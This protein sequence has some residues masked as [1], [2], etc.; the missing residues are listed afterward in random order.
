MFSQLCEGV[1]EASSTNTE[2]LL[3]P[4]KPG[5][6][7]APYLYRLAFPKQDYVSLLRALEDKNL[8][9]LEA[10]LLDLLPDAT[11]LPG[12]ES[13]EWQHTLQGIF[14]IIYERLQE[15]PKLYDEQ[16]IK[17]G[18]LALAVLPDGPLPKTTED[19]SSLNEQC[20]TAIVC[21]LFSPQES[22]RIEF[23][24]AVYSR[25]LQGVMAEACWNSTLTVVEVS[26]DENTTEKIPAVA[27]KTKRVNNF[28]DT[29]RGTIEQLDYYIQLVGETLKEQAGART[30]NRPKQCQKQV[31]EGYREGCPD[32]NLLQEAQEQS[33]ADPEYRSFLVDPYKIERFALEQVFIKAQMDVIFPDQDLLNSP[34][35]ISLANSRTED[36]PQAIP[37]TGVISGRFSTLQRDAQASLEELSAPVIEKFRLPKSDDAEASLSHDQLINLRFL[38]ISRH[39]GQFRNFAKFI[40][41]K[42]PILPFIASNNIWTIAER[43][44]DAPQ[45][46][47]SLLHYLVNEALMTRARTGEEA[48]DEE[49]WQLA[50]EHRTSLLRLATL[51]IADF[52]VLINANGRN[53]PLDPYNSP[54]GTSHHGRDHGLSREEDG[55]LTLTLPVTHSDAIGLAKTREGVTLGCPALKEKKQDVVSQPRSSSR[56]ANYIDYLLAVIINEARA[57]GDLDLR[58]YEET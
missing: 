25:G 35:A 38:E 56:T 4:D 39:T 10:G 30:P 33:V 13:A 45:R 36:L 46:A 22:D 18:E 42:N 5:Q 29:F 48:T 19:P 57:R 43:G 8:N 50:H 17:W 12:E 20:L 3:A 16:N 54:N 1:S 11:N 21:S 52:R 6:L 58:N 15:D 28:A 53:R 2:L 26:G 51:N 9:E 41:R 27:Y 44:A 55:Q 40:D 24:K 31:A 37:L 14:S 34:F 7:L 49:L 32:Q 23:I 47:A